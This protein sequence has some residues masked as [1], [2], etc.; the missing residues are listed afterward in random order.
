MQSYIQILLARSR[1]QLCAIHPVAIHSICDECFQE[2]LPAVSCWSHFPCLFNRCVRSGESWTAAVTDD[3]VPKLCDNIGRISPSLILVFICF[4]I[5]SDAMMAGC[6]NVETYLGANV[7]SGLG[8]TGYTIATQIYFASTTNIVSRAFWNVAADS[9]SAII[10][11][12]SGAEIGGHIL[13][14][15]GVQSGWRWGYGMWCSA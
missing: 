11:M 4:T 6:K 8:G 3:E 14:N 7:F 15:W 12:Y 1:F 5:I 9:I 2:S 13:S 10:T